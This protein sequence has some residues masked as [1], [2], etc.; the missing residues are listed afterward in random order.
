MRSIVRANKTDGEKGG[1]GAGGDG[2]AKLEKGRK[3]RRPF[4]VA[5]VSP[6]VALPVTYKPP[7]PPQI[8]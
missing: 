7:P 8:K 3:G 6:P 4:A 5:P 1:G 2:R